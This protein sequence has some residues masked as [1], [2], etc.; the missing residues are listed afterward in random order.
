MLMIIGGILLAVGGL[1]GLWL[2]ISAFKQGGALQGLL[3]MFVPFYLLYFAF[4]KYQ[5]PKKGLVVGSYLGAT[6]LGVILWSVGGVMMANDAAEALNADLSALQ[7]TD[8]AN[9]PAAGELGEAAP[10]A[11]AT[12]TCNEI[13]TNK[14]CYHV[15][16]PAALLTGNRAGCMGEWSE[17]ENCP[18][19]NVAATCEKDM[20]N[21][22]RRFY[23]G[24]NLANAETAC[25]A[26]GGTFTNGS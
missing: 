3:S 13:A 22:V 7:A 4:A 26:F 1:F 25:T 6:I 12:Y 2:L 18:T 17:G 24:V 11:N 21:E 20:N 9:P 19:E 15:S 5:S 8:F 10:A 23:E 16:P 14:L